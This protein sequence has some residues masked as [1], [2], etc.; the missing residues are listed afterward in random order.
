MAFYYGKVDPETYDFIKRYNKLRRFATDLNA[1]FTSCDANAITKAIQ[2]GR[3]CF[4]DCANHS[5]I[6]TMETFSNSNL[7]MIITVHNT[8]T[9]EVYKFFV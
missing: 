5:E 2:F 6:V 1:A 3:K 7:I 8:D 4:L 9:D